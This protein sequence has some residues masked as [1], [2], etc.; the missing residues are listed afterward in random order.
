M[1]LV[2]LNGNIFSTDEEKLN[3]RREHFESVLHHV[4]SSEVSPFAPTIETTSP[5][6]TI[7]QI[8]TSKSE[9]ISATKFIFAHVLTEEK[10]DEV[11]DAFYTNLENLYDRPM[12]SI[13]S[14]G[15]ST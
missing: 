9:T 7:R 2:D 4:V 15:I 8:P 6:R 10:D 11:N 12:T 1:H 3:T 13:L 14:S 5:A